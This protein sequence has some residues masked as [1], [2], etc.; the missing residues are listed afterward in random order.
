VTAL[1]FY[2]GDGRILASGDDDKKIIVWNLKEEKPLYPP[3]EGHTGQILDLAFSPHG[4]LLMSAS[5]SDSFILGWD[6]QSGKNLGPREFDGP[7]LSLAFNPVVKSS[8]A[9]AGWDNRVALL[10]TPPLPSLRGHNAAVW[11]VA[12]SPDG[13]KIASGSQDGTVILW[14]I[15]PSL[16]GHTKVVR[17]VA[18]SPDSKTLASASEDK[19]IVF[20]DVKTRQP[21]SAFLE[22]SE[23]INCMTFSPDGELIASGG[24]DDVVTLWNVRTRQK[25]GS[26]LQ[27]L[28]E[29]VMSVAFSPDGKMVAA[30]GVNGAIGL[31]DTT[32][33]KL[34]QPLPKEHKE[35]VWA[36]S[37]SSKGL[38]AS[39]DR[40]GNI[41]LWDISAGK[42]I[43][44]IE[45]HLTG[46]IQTIKFSPD[47]DLL[48]A[49][50]HGRTI[51]FFDVSSRRAKL[52]KAVVTG[53]LGPVL[54]LAFIPDG[55]TLASGSIDG[56]VAF[57][58]VTSYQQLGRPMIRHT[59]SVWSVSFSP[60]GRYMAS[61]SAD[62]S[63]FLWDAD[64]RFQSLLRRSRLMANR[65]L[66]TEERKQYPVDYESRPLRSLSRQNKIK[67][68][69]SQ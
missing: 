54:S 6:V 38:L 4:P 53:Q 20:W 35:C 29:A 12:F 49:G 37:F 5:G 23:N 68:R 2:K 61:G 14:D 47:G 21:Q 32:T 17:S 10:G 31:W 42:S 58:D 25:V 1:S 69:E 59:D 62:A 65:E 48:V 19:K 52:L 44:R 22:S 15:S 34:L 9:V 39:S 30:G 40:R 46:E 50:S 51:Y 7:I 55:K 27:G 66:T 16:L 28:K 43:D 18:F 63:V 13:K 26:P 8:L 36:I 56:T 60:D 67:N 64:F 11:S 41:I 3:L 57:W 24:G 45:K 33:H